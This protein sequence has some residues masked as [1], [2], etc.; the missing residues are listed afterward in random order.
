MGS[1]YEVTELMDKVS[2]VLTVI[3]ELVTIYQQLH[4][5]GFFSSDKWRN[6]LL[7]V[8]THPE[9]YPHTLAL[10]GNLHDH[11]DDLPAIEEELK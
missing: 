6:K 7:D 4:Q 11:L 9:K 5:A 10:V 3:Q 1:A 2:L 8:A